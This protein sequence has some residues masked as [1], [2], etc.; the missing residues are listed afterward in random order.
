[1][2]TKCQE[3]VLNVERWWKLVMSRRRKR[4]LRLAAISAEINNDYE[5]YYD[6]SDHTCSFCGSKIRDC[7]QDHGDEMR[8]IQRESRI[9]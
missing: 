3:A 4:T 1:M 9:W 7:G 2:S 8:D 6:N 5:D